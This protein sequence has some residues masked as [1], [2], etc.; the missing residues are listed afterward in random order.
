MCAMTEQWG[1]TVAGAA[2][3]VALASPPQRE[4]RKVRT[5]KKTLQ[6]QQVAMTMPSF[7]IYCTLWLPSPPPPHPLSR[8]PRSQGHM[9]EL[10]QA[11][12]ERTNHGHLVQPTSCICNSLFRSAQPLSLS[13]RTCH[14]KATNS[15]LYICTT[16]LVCI[17]F[18]HFTLLKKETGRDLK[19][20]TLLKNK[21]LYENF[22]GVVQSVGYILA[23]LS[24]ML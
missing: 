3:I 13:L 5:C 2:A 1:S 21:F 7:P 17:Y 9:V 8:P 6:C 19:V 14:T 24:S 22:L 18:L 20:F 12:T 4:D 15:I 11:H 10:I 16:S 23:V